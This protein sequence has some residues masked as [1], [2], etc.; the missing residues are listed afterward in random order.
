MK[1][2]LFLSVSLAFLQ[3]A[4]AGDAAN[5]AYSQADVL[6]NLI[7]Q[8]NLGA[9]RAICIGTKSECDARQPKPSGFDMMLT[10]DLDS[11][12]LLPEAKANLE[13]VA[14]A[15]QDE[16]LRSAKFM[17]EGH[18][19]ARG[20]EQYNM[21]LSEARAKAVADFLH[22]RNVDPD[23]IAAIG[24]GETAPRSNDPYD[25]QNRFVELRL[26]VE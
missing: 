24:L 2:A 25:P 16:R 21:N 14:K 9:A 8:T 13:V 23:R 20:T 12:E 4:F 3:P 15:L 11:A 5:P 17:V 1:K 7:A 18:T 19:D 22:E 10:F 26:S 6:A